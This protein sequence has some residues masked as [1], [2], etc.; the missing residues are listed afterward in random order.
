M[1]A[2]KSP[3]PIKSF[4]EPSTPA[5]E[6][7][8]KIHTATGW[9]L[10]KSEKLC[11]ILRRQLENKL[12][13][14]Y[15]GIS[16][17]QVET[18]FLKFG[19]EENFT[20]TLCIAQIDKVLRKYFSHQTQ[21]NFDDERRLTTQTIPIPTPSQHLYECRALL[22]HKYQ[23]Y[24]EKKLNIELIPAF[25]WPVLQKDYGIIPELP[26]LFVIKAKQFIADR[27]G[28]NKIRRGE[29]LSDNVATMEAGYDNTENVSIKLALE[30]AFIEFEKMG[31]KHLYE[32]I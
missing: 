31:N 6:L 4:T 17:D 1:E 24:L 11:S 20:G 32:K 15:P 13:F 2:K 16:H 14:D 8:F 12:H 23:L 27:K 5:N 7:L 21:Q 26:A 3:M 28:N 18:A 19:S 25:I 22:E 9:R 29:S 10:P 30:C